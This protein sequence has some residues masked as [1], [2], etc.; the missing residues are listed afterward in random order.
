MT[1]S[2]QH[3]QKID[4][5]VLKG[6]M[7]S[8]TY[9]TAMI[10]IGELAEYFPPIDSSDMP[11][12]D[13]V[14][15]RLT[16]ARIPQISSF[17][18]TNPEK[19]IFPSLIASVPK[20]VLKF[21]ANGTFSGRLWG[22]LDGVRMYINDGQ[23]RVAGLLHALIDFPELA[24]QQISVLIFNHESTRDA[25]QM[26]N[27]LNAYAR[28]VPRGLNIAFDHSPLANVV[29]NL[30]TGAVPVFDGLIE[31]EGSGSLPKKSPMLLSN[32]S[33]LAATTAYLTAQA[34][35]D[36]VPTVEQQT[37]NAAE[38]WQVVA[39]CFPW[40]QVKSAFL[41]APELRQNNL[42][43]HAPIIQAIGFLGGQARINFGATWKK[44]L[45]EA[46]GKIDFSRANPDWRRQDVAVIVGDS[47]KSDRQ[48]KDGARAYLLERSG[49]ADEIVA[50]RSN[51]VA[52]A[53]TTTAATAKAAPSVAPVRKRIAAARRN[54]PQSRTR[55]T[56]RV[57]A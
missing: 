4:L 12:A 21:K 52:I 30:A 16:K 19:W 29:R 55:R 26:F 36:E 14:Q 39:K 51:H 17:V 11:T 45:I 25:Q 8:R 20:G 57:A 34:T 37:A 42:S 22:I 35:K 10:P 50:S 7:G 32:V 56:T 49:W 6:T 54:A 47:V 46:L 2:I 15:R 38:F 44:R 40:A 33:L 5:E 53:A 48:A 31:Q 18:K 27:F 9:Y 3:M 13:K 23:H 41:P 1:G 43:T 24:K 28:Q